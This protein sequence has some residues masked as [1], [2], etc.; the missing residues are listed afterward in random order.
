LDER[1]RQPVPPGTVLK[2]SRPAAPVPQEPS[3]GRVLVTT[4][5]VSVSWRLRSLGFRPQGASG[6]SGQERLGAPQGGLATSRWRLAVLVVALAV[7]AVISLRFTGLF[8]GPPPGRAGTFR[9]QLRRSQPRRPAF[10]PGRD[11]TGPGRGLDCGP[12]ERRR[13]YRLPSRHVRGAAGAR[14]NRGTADAGAGR[15]GQSARRHRDGDVYFGRQSA[16][17][18]VRARSDR[19]L[20]VGEMTGST[21]ARPSPAE[22][23]HTSPRCGLISPRARARARSCARTLTS[24]SPRRTP[25]SS[26]RVRWIRACWPRSRCWRR[27]TRSRW[28]RSAIPLPAC[29]FCSGT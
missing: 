12:G 15:G 5:E 9:S 7:I 17:Q 22:R 4:I 26:G 21:S 28:P 27:S 25:R 3:W 29:R 16:G 1:T 24:V 20:R 6:R 11:D 2:V 8:T 10:V 13:D 23:L 14:R 18:Q 19:K